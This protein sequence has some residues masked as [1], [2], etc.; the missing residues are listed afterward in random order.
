MAEAFPELRVVG[1]S[2]F[3]NTGHA[4]CVN[5]ANEVVDP[6]AHQFHQPFNYNCTRLELSDFPVGKCHWCGELMWR[7]TPGVRKYLEE[8]G[9]DYT[10]VGPHVECDRLCEES[11]KNDTY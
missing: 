4:W 8:I 5:I 9:D 3:D 7:D 2:Y 11:I 1:V 6:T 10:V